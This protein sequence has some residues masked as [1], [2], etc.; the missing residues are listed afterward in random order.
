MI[1]SILVKREYARVRR[2]EE[3]FPASL[4]ITR[5]ESGKD[6]YVDIF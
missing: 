4:Q 2:R 3:M 6:A 1:R 5:L